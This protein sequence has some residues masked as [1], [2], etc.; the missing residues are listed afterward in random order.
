MTSIWFDPL[1]KAQE[2]S[3]TSIESGFDVEVDMEITHAPP[4]EE[5]PVEETPVE[6]GE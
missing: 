2:S 3:V 6:E 1:E 5:P 4:A